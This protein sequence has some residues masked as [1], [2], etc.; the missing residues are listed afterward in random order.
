MLV[1]SGTLNRKL[2]KILVELIKDKKAM[3]SHKIKKASFNNRKKEL[4]TEYESGKKF[5]LHYGQLGIKQN[6]LSVWVD[7]ETDGLSL[8]IKLEDGSEEYMPY[9]QPLMLCHDPEYTLQTDIERLI[10]YIRETIQKQKISKKY[11]AEQLCTST[12]QVQRLL[13]PK[14]LNKNLAQLY[15]TSALLGLELEWQIKR[16]A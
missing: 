7:K 4:F 14:I 10:A 12:N 2:R 15:K 5:T 6:L 13:D 11:I 1:L 16:A 3:K 9:D 8:G